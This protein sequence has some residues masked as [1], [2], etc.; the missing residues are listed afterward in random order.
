M[1]CSPRRDVEVEV[2]LVINYWLERSPGLELHWPSERINY[3]H[4]IDGP[5][6]S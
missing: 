5:L 3:C 1:G 6:D 4:T 2:V